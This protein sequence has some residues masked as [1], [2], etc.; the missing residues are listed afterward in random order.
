MN[1]NYPASVQLFLFADKLVPADS[2]FSASTLIPYSQKKVKTN[3]LAVLLLAFTI[4]DLLQKNCINLSVKKSMVMLLI[5]SST[6]EVSLDKDIPVS[7]DLENLLLGCMNRKGTTLKNVIYQ[8]LNEHSAWPHKQIIH[9]VTENTSAVGLGSIRNNGTGMKQMLNGFSGNTGFEP[10]HT[11]I[12]PLEPAF[13]FMQQQWNDFCFSSA[14]TSGML[15][16]DCRSA[17]NSRITQT[18]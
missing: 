11:L 13:N 14:K 8:L 3:D 1:Q 17:L 5:P 10:N 16:T 18:D 2:A 15:V 4:W 9:I 7:G 6:L 12:A